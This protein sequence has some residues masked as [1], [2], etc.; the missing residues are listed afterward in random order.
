[1]EGGALRVGPQL[2]GSPLLC[3]DCQAHD[4]RYFCRASEQRRTTN[5]SLP[6]VFNGANNKQFFQQFYKI[7]KNYQINLKNRKLTQIKLCCPIA[8]RNKF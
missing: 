1:V 2:P 4:K 6:C 7:H 8:Y 3:V 5:T